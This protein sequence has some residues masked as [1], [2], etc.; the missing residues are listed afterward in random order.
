MNDSR[1][2]KNNRFFHAFSNLGIFVAIILLFITGSIVNKNF[3]SPANLI[4]ILQTGTFLMMVCTG[5][6]FVIYSG[7]S[8]DLSVPTSIALAGTLC[9]LWLP[10][11]LIPAIALS[12]LLGIC[13]GAING[14]VIGKFRANPVIWTMS[15]NFLL[16]GTFRW[17]TQNRQFYPDS[18]PG[19]TP[20][21]AQAFM[22]LSRTYLFGRLPLTVLVVV[23]MVSIAQTVL[24][25][26]SFGRQLMVMGCN[27]QAAKYSG[28]SVVWNTMLVYGISGL[29][30]AV[31]GIFLVSFATFG[32][33]TIG[34]GYDFQAI[35]AIVVGGMSLTG[36]RGDF[37][38]VI[39][40][41]ITVRMLA[42][43][44]TFMGFGT[45]YQYI[46]IGILCI[47]IV[48]TNTNSLRK[49]GKDGI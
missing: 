33:S 42:N 10:L 4:G 43:V 8:A 23:I 40:G 18:I 30:A 21:T 16:D 19:T 20:E 49:L 45:Y 34:A 35:T 41:A 25:T 38:K 47:T 5:M 9:E 15:V 24:K 27:Y 39:G 17:V 3:Y 2:I 7:N 12:L 22:A 29:A 37:I 11:G 44:L 32:N 14:F 1:S 36:G 31:A 46:A 48:Y 13:I 6:G 28:I 26:T